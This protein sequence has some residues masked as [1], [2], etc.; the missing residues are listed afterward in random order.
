MVAPLK[1]PRSSWTTHPNYPQQVLLLGSH[2]SFRATSRWL[3]AQARQ[4]GH[5]S[6]T[7]ASF[8]WW[9]SAMA[10]H[11]HYE[12]G[13]LYPF[14]EH[15]WGVCIH[16]RPPQRRWVSDLSLDAPSDLV[17][18]HPVATAQVALDFPGHEARKGSVCAL[19]NRL[20]LGGLP[21]G[22]G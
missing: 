3:V 20:E 13:K 11:E 6:P 21:V 9:K 16:A 7:L 14:L 1:L 15:R 18:L 19:D 8:S 10:G 5:R 2:R 4:G 22:L 17:A 12:E